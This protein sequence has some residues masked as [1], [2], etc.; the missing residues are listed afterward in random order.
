MNGND[1]ARGRLDGFAMATLTVLCMCW[2]LNQV[3]VK[4]A[5]EGITPFTQ[6]AIRSF[7]AAVLLIGWAR[8]RNIALFARD[9][10]LLAGMIAGILFGIEFLLIYWGLVY[11]TAS[12]AIVFIYTAPF[13]VAAG[14]H[15]FVPG[16]RLTPVR[17]GGL[18]AALAGVILA[19]ADELSLPSPRALI[20]D[21]MCLG[22]A[23][24]WGATTVLVK[25][26]KL[27]RISAEKTLFYQLAVSAAILGVAAVAA[28]ESGAF[29]PTPLVVASVAY[30]TVV[31][32]F[33][34]YTA[35]FSLVTRYPASLLASF[36]FLTP[37]FGVLA[38]CLVLGEPI[39]LKLLGAVALIAA[40][41][42][43]VNR[44]ARH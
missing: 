9:G 28:S 7:G 5:N 1:G 34:S 15:L 32:A 40:G 37:V 2:G 30:Q 10:T 19:F 29:A 14:A 24:A 16:D 13:V 31:V 23:I 12:R 11:T 3:S 20:G 4:L 42:Y 27:S 36:S 41:I 22:G 38:G 6:A 44:P 39:G 17:L 33:A 26:T 43:L 25:A 21:A 18:V 8:W 35:W